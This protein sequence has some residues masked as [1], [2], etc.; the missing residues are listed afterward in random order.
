MAASERVLRRG[1]RWV[2][3]TR[4]D[5]A[6]WPDEGLRK[7]D[8]VEHYEAIAPVL[9]PHLRDRPFTM[10]RHYTG[11]RSPFAWV[12]DA[13]PELPDWIPT[14]T[15]PAKS[16]GGETVAY[17]VVNDELALLWMV[18]YGAIDLH[19][20][21]SRCDRPNRPDFVLFDLDPSPDVGFRETVQAALLVRDALLALGLESY[22]K[23][24]GGDGLHV[25]VPVARRYSYEQTREFA[26]VVADALRV[27]YPGLVTTE[28]AK[29]KRRGVFIDA[30]MNGE[31]MT[32]ASVYSVRPRAGA[33]VAT[34][35]RWEE[36]DADLD[37]RA[38]T[39]DVVLARLERE[40]DLFAPL[41]TSRQ[42]LEGAFRLLG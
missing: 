36:L 15:L 37:P 12:K 14:C 5:A 6:F 34:P 9:L 18:E 7:R 2:Q 41:L 17:P 16:R 38:F 39:M 27:A 40:G 31:G 21:Y 8:L 33:P 25:H 32:V 11:P 20:W 24:S 26:E 22:V 30:K 4:L 35:L 42:R 3:L 19:L 10:K 28:W 1:R 23:T 13:P 29:E